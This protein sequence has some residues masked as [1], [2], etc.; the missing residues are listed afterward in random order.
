MLGRTPHVRP[1][2]RHRMVLDPRRWLPGGEQVTRACACCAGRTDPHGFPCTPCWDR[3]CRPL[4]QELGVWQ[5][6]RGAGCP[7]HKH[8][9]SLEHIPPVPSDDDLPAPALADDPM[10]ARLRVEL[11]AR[12]LLARGKKQGKRPA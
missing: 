2:A 8:E 12:K 6:L 1:L 3:G 11:A 10:H 9:P 4:R 7:R 5:W